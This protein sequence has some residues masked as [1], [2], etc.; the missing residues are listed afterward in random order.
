MNSQDVGRSSE[1]RVQHLEDSRIRDDCQRVAVSTL[2]IQHNDILRA[3]VY[4][5]LHLPRGEAMAHKRHHARLGSFSVSK[6]EA[7]L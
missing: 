7:G 2:L 3:M 1:W 5:M 4:K 6:A